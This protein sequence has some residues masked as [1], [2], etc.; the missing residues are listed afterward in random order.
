M[1][2]P[3][4]Q[5]VDLALNKTELLIQKTLKAQ[6]PQ[7]Y[8]KIDYELLYSQ[9]S[10]LSIDS[11]D[12]KVDSVTSASDQGL[13][14]RILINQRCGFAS[15]TSLEPEAIEH[16][17]QAAL[18][19]ATLLPQDPFY[20]FCHV[21]QPNPLSQSAQARQNYDDTGLKLDRA[22]K[23][24][25]AIHLENLCRNYRSP[26]SQGTITGVRKATFKQ[27]D[28]QE[29]I[30]TNRTD[31]KFQ[32][33]S[34]FLLNLTC[35]AEL[36]GDSQMGY[37]SIITHAYKDLNP[38]SVV[39]VAA[40][41]A[42]ELLKAQRVSS[43]VGP[44]IVKN[45]VA[46]DLLEFI[47][48]SFSSENVAKNKSFLQNKLGQELFSKSVSLIDDGTYSGGAASG[49]FDAEGVPHRQHVLI[50]NGQVKNFLYDLY[51]A[52]LFKVEPTG[53]A[54]RAKIMVPPSIG[55]TNLYL[56]TPTD[57]QTPYESM[58]KDIK[59]GI[60]LTEL[61]GLH[62]ANPVTGDFSLGAAGL[63]IENGKI[64][65]AIKGFAVSGNCFKLLNQIHAVAADDFRFF[66][67]VGTASWLIP[68]LTISG[69]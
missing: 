42:F 57:F 19:I 51:H 5:T 50:Q 69:D 14:I 21:N 66:G 32:Q 46:A 30:K 24:Q 62:T 22:E 63:L 1:Q 29:G 67:S 27:V 47:S 13:A 59:K 49:I 8:Q 11:K 64:A 7:E 68:E 55:T 10:S 45:A 34:R 25:L 38:Q 6:F 33:A 26:Q 61:L 20:Q 58:I 18:K 40:E 16:A 12:L 3:H 15:T 36:D 65:H 60:I 35:K 52:N 56:E 54:Q 17:I 4:H 41:G 31:V 43:F 44:C 48:S 23:I 2:T 9:R 28:I 39:H 53:H 37:E